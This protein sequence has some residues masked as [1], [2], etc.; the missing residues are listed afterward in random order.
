T[1][2]NDNATT[3]EDTPVS[4]NVVSNDTDLDG[5]VNPATVDLDPPK[6]GIQSNAHTP[7]GDFVANASG[8][9][10]FTPKKKFIGTATIRYKI[11]DND[12][13]TSI[14]AGTITITVSDVNTP[15]VANND[16]A[17]TNE[18]T[19]VTVNIVANDTDED[20]SINATTVDLDPATGGVQKT[21]STAQGS[22]SV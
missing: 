5:N 9:V 6:G 21:H 12:G 11:N 18:N 1:A 3:N 10:T 4:I 22:F 7:Q 19:S 13:A 17:E 20:G 14:F 8:I 15:P 2:N 16:A